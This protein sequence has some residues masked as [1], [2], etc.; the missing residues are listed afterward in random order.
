MTSMARLSSTTGYVYDGDGKRV[1]KTGSAPKLYWDGADG[2]VLA[3]SD[4][5]GETDLTGSFANGNF[6]EYIFFGGRRI[7]KRDSGG[8]VFYYMADSLGTSRAMAQVLSGQSTAA[9]CY[10]AD[11]YPFGGERVEQ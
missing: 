6:S 8:N 2:Q 4:E 9:P 10:D 11:Y 3:V 5:I 7:A 1:E